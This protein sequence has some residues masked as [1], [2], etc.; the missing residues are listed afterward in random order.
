MWGKTLV[1]ASLIGGCSAG[2]ASEAEEA[3]RV[4]A[5]GQPPMV[6][7]L[8]DN[9]GAAEPVSFAPGLEVG[10]A[11][12]GQGQP[13]NVGSESLCD[14]IDENNNGI[15]DD[16]DIGQDGLCDCLRIGFL[17]DL[18][19]DA[20]NATGAFEEWLEARSDF[21]VT[22]IE[23]NDPLLA[24][25]L[26]ALQVVV[27]G[28]L[29]QR[30]NAGGYSEEEV[31]ILSQWVEAGGGVITLAGYTARE[32]D[33][34]S[35]AQ[36]LEPMGVGYDYAGRGPGVLGVGA[37]P[38]LVN[39]ILLPDHPTMD[40]ISTMGVYN[41]YPVTG[42]GEVILTDGTFDLAMVKGFGEGQVFVFSDE[43]VTQDALWVPG[44][45]QQRPLTQC[46]RE[47]AQCAMECGSCDTQCTACSEQP[48]Q[49]GELPVEGEECAR[50]CDQACGSC[51]DRCDTCEASCAACSVDEVTGEL[52]IPRFWLN[53]MR[54]LTPENECQ[55]PVP[56]VLR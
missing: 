1:G 16:V 33:M 37:P 51:T 34:S 14:G 18:A 56:A 13:L 43:W 25:S 26:A 20:G 45:E 10:P 39:Q 49:G 50:G 23:A 44:A 47:C 8:G 27:V 30:V 9:S 11:V 46:Q 17:G 15:V 7:T 35:T 36:L 52:D 55:V 22:H 19:S 41:A 42:D 28:N 54:W 38:V 29:A 21:A 48:C 53:V 5:S 6:S 3:T 24:T 31:N 4:Q 2:G 12:D 32:D 40:G